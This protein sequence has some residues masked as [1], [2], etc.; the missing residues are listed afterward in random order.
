[1][2][3]KIR[4]AVLFLQLGTDLAATGTRL[5]RARSAAKLQATLAAEIAA[6]NAP[7]PSIWREIQSAGHAL[8]EARVRVEALALR[9]EIT[10]ETEI[11][12]NV[13]AGE[14]GGAAHLAAGQTFSTRGDGALTVDIPEVGTFRVTGPSGN[15]AEW[16]TKHE[17]AAARLRELV[18]PFGVSA[19]QELEERVNRRDR[20]A[21]GLLAAKA[22]CAALLGNDRLDEVEERL[23]LTAVEHSKL[24]GLEPSWAEKLPDV[25]ALRAEAGALKVQLENAQNQARIAWQNA[26][27]LSSGAESAGSHNSNACSANESALGGVEDRNRS[28][29]V[30]RFDHRRA[31]GKARRE[32]PGL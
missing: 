6:W 18:D 21:P 31:P 4:R 22:E 30:G 29:G 17:K 15:A 8:D 10:A 7:S 26:V 16:R 12:A 32:T 9:L 13:I 25:A 23:R 5:E 28:T 2:E 27:R 14:P 11:T 3:E 1:M 20:I 19:W 24:L